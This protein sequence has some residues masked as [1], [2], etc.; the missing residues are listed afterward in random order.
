MSVADKTLASVITND[1]MSEL[2]IKE[3]DKVYAIF[4]AS[5]VILGA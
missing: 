2:K 3:G 5:N 4:K 1:A